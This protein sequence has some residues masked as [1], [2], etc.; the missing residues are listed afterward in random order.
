[1][2]TFPLLTGFIFSSLLLC[3]EAAAQESISNNLP[4]VTV[5][6][7][8]AQMKKALGADSVLSYDAYEFARNAKSKL[9]G[10]Y[11]L[12]KVKI[13]PQY[14]SITV[15]A[16]VEPYYVFGWKKGSVQ[17]INLA[18]DRI[19]MV[20][21]DMQLIQVED[22]MYLRAKKNGK[23]GQ[24]DLFSGKL[25][26]PYEFNR[27]ED[28]KLR[29][30]DFGFFFGNEPEVR[31]LIGADTIIYNEATQEG[32]M[33]ARSAKNGK[34]GLFRKAAGSSVTTLIPMFYD[35]I[36]MPV[37]SEIPYTIVWKNGKAGTFGLYRYSKNIALVDCIYEDAKLFTDDE[38]IVHFAAKQNGKW[39]LV[40]WYNGNVI[41]GF[42]FEKASDV[43]VGYAKRSKWY[44]GEPEPKK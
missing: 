19:E 41:T 42:T 7:S 12:N 8:A 11:F 28:V 5:P 3:T 40:D 24:V 20:A 31:K 39:G 27:A 29:E 44:D 35:S 25:V 6:D 33:I 32:Y 23:W 18:S 22:F 38:G 4:V 9:W 30:M 14:D 34:W 2:R 13:K 10:I 1:M 15:P 21:E 26:V 36:L 43:P 16:A 17:L 37:N